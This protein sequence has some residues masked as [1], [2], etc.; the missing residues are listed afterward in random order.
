VL[1]E[2]TRLFTMLVSGVLLYTKGIFLQRFFTSWRA[3]RAEGVERPFDLTL[4]DAVIYHT[5]VSLVVIG[6]VIGQVYAL[7][8]TYA[9][10]PAAPV[11]L[12]GLLALEVAVWRGAQNL[13]RNRDA[14]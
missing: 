5:G 4:F 3:Q 13:N 8:R 10:T 11:I 6:I 12:L 9:L 2:G 1:T 7:S 14:D